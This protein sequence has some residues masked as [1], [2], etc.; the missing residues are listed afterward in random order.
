MPKVKDD[1]KV[2]NNGHDPD[3]A[4]LDRAKIQKYQEE[5]EQKTVPPPYLAMYGKKGGELCEVSDLN[6]REIFWLSIGQTKD[7]A[8]NPECYKLNKTKEGYPVPFVARHW[9][10]NYMRLKISLKR[11]GR[12]EIVQSS[13]IDKEDELENPLTSYKD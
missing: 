13:Q 5:D 7:D 9:R 6:E 12:D 1:T 10:D 2:K 3:K 11:K 8:I 4:T